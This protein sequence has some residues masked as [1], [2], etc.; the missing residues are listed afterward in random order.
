M[1][2][3]NNRCV[4][5]EQKVLEPAIN[6]KIGNELLNINVGCSF[7]Y[8]MISILNVVYFHT[9]GFKSLGRYR[10]STLKHKLAPL[11]TTFAQLY[12]LHAYVQ[13]GL[14]H[15]IQPEIESV[16]NWGPTKKHH[17]SSIRPDP[18][19]QLQLRLLPRVLLRTS[20]NSMHDDAEI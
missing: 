5:D 1:S 17:N 10:D 13:E 9:S 14:N 15:G 8:W 3:T 6:V 4:N 19:W 11:R 16:F 12:L 18:N 7:D 20:Y 2:I